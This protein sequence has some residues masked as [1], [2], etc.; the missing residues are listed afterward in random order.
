LIKTKETLATLAANM[1]AWRRNNPAKA[2][3]NDARRYRNNPHR[4]LESAEWK[5]LNPEKMQEYRA[6]WERNNPEKVRARTATKRAR[7]TTAPGTGITARQRQGILADSLGLCA[8]CNERRPLALDH[9]EPLFRGGEHDESNAA[10]ACKP[11]N[12]SKCDTPLLVWL[13]IRA[14]AEV[15]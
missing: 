15:P 7:R 2:R 4:A 14:S 3:A 10:A 9:I 5:R 6:R 13:A 8:Y 1:R 12:S 11:C